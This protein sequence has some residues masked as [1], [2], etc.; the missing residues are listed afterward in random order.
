MKK[1][2]K[3]KRFYNKKRNV[4]KQKYRNKVDTARKLIERNFKIIKKFYFLFLNKSKN[5][6]NAS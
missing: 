2:I 6:L 4:N 3:R 1:N 5:G